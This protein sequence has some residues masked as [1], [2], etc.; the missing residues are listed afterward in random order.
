MSPLSESSIRLFLF[1]VFLGFKHINACFRG[2]FGDTVDL[3]Y[4]FQMY[5]IAIQNYYRLYSIY[6]YY[7]CLVIINAWL[8]IENRGLSLVVQG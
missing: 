2:F 6:S 1:S 5:N 3:Q 4:C 7:K 8:Q